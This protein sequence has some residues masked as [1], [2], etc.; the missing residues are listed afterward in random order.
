MLQMD[1]VAVPVVDDEGRILGDLTL[2]R[3]LRYLLS[4]SEEEAS[5]T[6]PSRTESAFVLAGLEAF[7]AEIE[8]ETGVEA[9]II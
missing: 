5:W 9:R 2:S 3:A 4:L 1:L 6:A 8:A 7:A